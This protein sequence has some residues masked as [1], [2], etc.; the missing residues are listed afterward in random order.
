MLDIPQWVE[1]FLQEHRGKQFA[2]KATGEHGWLMHV[3]Y[4]GDWYAWYFTA[5]SDFSCPILHK[6]KCLPEH[7]GFYPVN[8]QEE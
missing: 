4:N 7:Y 6:N 1:D 3:G 8:R 5:S 2:N